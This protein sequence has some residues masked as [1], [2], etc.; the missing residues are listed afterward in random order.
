[1]KTASIISAFLLVLFTGANL[2]GTTLQYEVTDLGTLG[3]SQSQ[4]YGVNNAGQVTGYSYTTSDAEQHAFQYSNGII[5]DL[6]TLGG[7][8]SQGY[9]INLAGQVTGYSA[10]VGDSVTHAFT[11]INGTMTDLG[12]L[13]GQSSKG[14]ALN[15]VGQ[16]TGQADD[17][18]GNGHA[19]LYSNGTISDLGTLGGSFSYGSSINQSGQIAGTSSTT[20]DSTNHAFIHQNG[21][22]TDLG[23]LGGD[24]SEGNGIN[25][26]GQVTGLSYTANNAATHAFIYSNGTMTDLGTL[27]GSYSAGFSINKSGQVTG[28]S[29]YLANNADT[30]PFIYTGGE[31]HDLYTI[32]DGVSNISLSDFGT[33]INDWGQIVATATV[34]SG[35][36]HAV[37]LSPITPYVTNTGASITAKVVYGV[38]YSAIGGTNSNAG[39]GTGVNL[40][41]TAGSNQNVVQTF[42]SI[43]PGLASDVLHL[44]GTAPDTIVLRMTYDKNTAIALFGSESEAYLGWLD[45]NDNTWKNSVYGNTGD[46]TPFFVSGAYDSN[47]DF[48]LGYYGVDTSNSEVWAVINHNSTFGVMGNIPVPVPEPSSAILAALTGVVAMMTRRRKV[49]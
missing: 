26:S 17:A 40:G 33:S 12:T 29:H 20:G 4:A 47:T 16:T 49:N 8:Y 18:S 48:V 28:Y 11:Y 46:N 10:I 14:Y 6:G 24:R 27:G 2:H 39:L 35:Q 41:G 43:I 45:P 36:T 15:A 23:T 21:V 22:M 7:S 31:M 30:H 34:S 44:S 3:G 38:D 1:M 25:E 32:V 5:S 19:F 9:G 13:G 42:S 37:L